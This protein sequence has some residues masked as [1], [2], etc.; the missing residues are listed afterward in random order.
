MSDESPVEEPV[1]DVPTDEPTADAP[2]EVLTPDETVVEEP[3]EVR[4]PLEVALER[5]EFAEKEIAYK[6]A[7]IQN[8][9]KRMMAEKA[10]AIQYGGMGMARR[11]LTILGDVDRAMT[12]IE[13]DDQSPVAQGLRLMRNKMWHELQAD[14]VASVEAKGAAFDPSKMEAIATI[15]ASDE[16]PNGTVVDVLE[17]GYTYK[18]KILVVARVVVASE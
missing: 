2:D 7:E 6:D 18:S 8:V 13:D 11:M 17:Q 4:D 1:E 14:G 9:R 15:P 5:A 3:E 12:G 16:H 10:E